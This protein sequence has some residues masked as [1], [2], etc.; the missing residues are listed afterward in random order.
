MAGRYNMVVNQGSTY[1]LKFTIKTDG[2]AWDL[3]GGGYTARMK[4]KPFFNST[5][6]SLE[7]TTENG[8]IVFST[9]TMGLVSLNIEA[10]A[11]E[12]LTPGKQIYDLEFE[13]SVGTVQ[14]I[15]EGAFL[16]R[17]EVTT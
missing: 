7:L 3:I 1:N 9:I 5:T 17:P 10:G 2:V 14:R 16:V 12:T 11:T 8:R 4:V 15:L 6:T 13:D